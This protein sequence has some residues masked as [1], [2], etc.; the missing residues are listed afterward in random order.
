MRQIRLR[1]P[2]LRLRS[3]GKLSRI[4]NAAIDLLFPLSCVV[5]GRE[6]RFLCNGCAPGL[7]RLQKPYCSLC[8]SP[9]APRLCSWCEA[10]PPSFDGIAAPYLMA[11]PVRDTVLGLKYRNLR[12]WAP[13]MGR[14]MTE[15]MESEPIDADVL[16]P[17]PLHRRRVRYRGYNQS[18]LLAREISRRTDIPMNP[19]V[20]SRNRDT[21]PQVSMSSGEE[22]RQNMAGAFECT[23]DVLGKRVLLIDD[24]VTTGATISACAGPLK[25]AGALSV[26]ALALAR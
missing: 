25:S 10:S 9:G 5:C 11:G 12:A 7:P 1:N 17:V 18:E 19:K 4:L 6:G 24:V 15:Y 23:G 20:L 14:L 21:P 8:A 3:D 13:H 22:R 26:R 16:V 2:D